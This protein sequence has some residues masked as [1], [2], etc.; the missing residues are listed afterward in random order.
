MKTARVVK[1]VFHLTI[2]TLQKVLPWPMETVQ[3]VKW[4]LHLTIP[5]L[6]KVLPWPMETVQIVKWGRFLLKKNNILFFYKKTSPLNDLDRFH[7][8]G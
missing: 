6:L 5:T 4:V 7:W 2:P 1:T 3:I 8:P